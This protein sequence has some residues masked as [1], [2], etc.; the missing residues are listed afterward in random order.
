MEGYTVGTDRQTAAVVCVLS[1]KEQPTIEQSTAQQDRTGKTIDAIR[2]IMQE[3]PAGTIAG[4]SVMLRDGFAM[5]RRDGNVLGITAGLLASVVL[6][7]LFR[8]IRW[9]ALCTT[10]CSGPSLMVNS[11]PACNSWPKNH[12]G[13][14]H[15]F[16]DDHRRS[17]RNYSSHHC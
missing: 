7:V 16:R 6:L 8:S 2:A 1:E 11:W 10:C 12:H 17:D 9:G 14:D 4:E 15:A 13:I 3:Y 5:L